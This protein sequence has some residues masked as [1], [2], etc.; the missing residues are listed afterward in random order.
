MDGKYFIYATP[1]QEQHMTEMF[2]VAPGPEEATSGY[3]DPSDPKW[4]QG[5]VP[6]I[7]EWHQKH[8][9]GKGGGT[10]GPQSGMTRG[11][12]TRDEWSPGSYLDELGIPWT[13]KKKLS[14]IDHAETSEH[15]TIR[16]GEPGH[17]LIEYDIFL[18][19]GSYIAIETSP[20]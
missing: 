11:E 9:G 10:F 17:P 1:E 4:T 3:L 12:P 13:H 16:E 2:G 19:D 8:P 5:T 7:Q 15:S 18:E 20:G 14:E 6:H